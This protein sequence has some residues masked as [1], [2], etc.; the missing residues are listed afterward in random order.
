LIDAFPEIFKERKEKSLTKDE[1]EM[2]RVTIL[3]TKK[4]YGS[5]TPRLPS[6]SSLPPVV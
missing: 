4:L 6:K 3:G 2:L 1:I 5:R